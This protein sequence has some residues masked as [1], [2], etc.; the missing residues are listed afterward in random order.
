MSATSASFKSGDWV[1]QRKAP[2]VMGQVTRRDG[3]VYRVRWIGKALARGRGGKALQRA[4]KLPCGLL[5]EGSLDSPLT[6][7][8]SE[9][10]ILAEWLESAGH[11]L[12]HKIIHC[13]EDLDVLRPAIA[14]TDFLF[15]HVNCHGG[16]HR[17]KGPYITLSP[18][19]K[20]VYLLEEST[21]SAFRRC[22]ASRSVL[23]SACELGKYEHQMQEF[24]KLAGLRWVAA[25]SRVVCDY[26]ALPF[27][28]CVY[29]G[30]L[31]HAWTF[32]TSVQRAIEGFKSMGILGGVGQGQTLVRLFG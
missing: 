30:I 6:S 21:Y 14:R 15:V 2:H 1:R 24:R 3:N 17:S 28:L 23:F 13:V 5:L 4:R 27:D 7:R 11:E 26:E 22:F 32:R 10:R 20:K 18:T 25:Y 12:A 29:L 16:Q 19:S 8:R 31:H 9:A